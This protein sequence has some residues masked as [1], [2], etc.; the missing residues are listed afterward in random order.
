MATNEDFKILNWYKIDILQ[1]S[2]DG[3]QARFVDSSIL[4][5]YSRH[6]L[7]DPGLMN[8]RY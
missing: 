8:M 4:Y 7:V 3:A 1:Y 2:H 6:G 5:L